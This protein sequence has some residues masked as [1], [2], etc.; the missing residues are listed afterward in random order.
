MDITNPTLSSQGFVRSLKAASD[1]PLV[2]GPS[3]IEIAQQAW[4]DASFYVPS[5]AEVIVDWIL[6]KFLKDKGKEMY[7]VICFFCVVVFKSYSSALNPVF[8]K[9]YWRLLLELVTS[10][11]TP[12]KGASD[13]RSIKTWLA[14]LLHRIPIGPVLVVFLNSFIHV[15]EEEREQLSELASSCLIILW[16]LAVQR[17]NSELLLECFGALLGFLFSNPLDAG[18]VKNGRLVVNSFRNSLSNSSNK[19]KVWVRPLYY[20]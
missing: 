9:R 19:K 20:I 15:H 18:F 6:S 11:S 8:D 2:G 12:Q 7:G 1:P 4:E 10:P 5:K 14:P 16:P 3:K 13:S 17:M